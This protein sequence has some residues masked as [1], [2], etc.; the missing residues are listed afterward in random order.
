MVL[1][2]YFYRTGLSSLFIGL[3]IA[4]GLAGSA[5]AMVLMSLAVDRIGRNHFLV[6]LSLVS[7]LGG[8]ALATTSSVPVLTIMAFVAMLNGTGTDRSAAFALDQ[9]VVPTLA[10]DVKRTWNLALYNLFLD[11]GGSLGLLEKPNLEARNWLEDYLKIRICHPPEHARNDRFR[12]EST[13]VRRSRH[14][15]LGSCPVHRSAQTRWPGVSVPG[16]P[17]SGGLALPGPGARADGRTVRPFLG[18]FAAKYGPVLAAALTTGMRPSEYLG[19]KWQD[20]DWVRQTISIVRGIRRMNGKWCFSDTKRS[21]SRRP[22]KLQSWIVSLLR[23][24]QTKAGAQDLYP[25]FHDLVF[26]T[27]SG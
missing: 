2:I 10:A 23:D 3:I 4:A 25:E 18:A 13:P 11:G 16:F 27:Q 20:I 9:A 22:I 6:A 19:L 21:R 7:A 26:R 14:G 12:R 24:L 8:I 1:G 17:Q 15:A 5:L